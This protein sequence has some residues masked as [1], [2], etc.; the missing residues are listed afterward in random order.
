MNNSTLLNAFG[1]LNP[2]YLNRIQ[3]V[4]NAA[5]SE[6]PRTL[7]IRFDLHLPVQIDTD[8]L[9]ERDMGLRV[10][11]TDHRV[12]TRF[13]DALK[14]RIKADL[15][16]RA[17]D[18]KRVHSTS[19]RYVRVTEQGKADQQH[20]HIGILLNADSYY[21][22]HSSY[23]SDLGLAGMIR[24]AWASALGLNINKCR[25]LL[26]FPN[27]CF[28]NINRNAVGGVYTEQYYAALYRLGYLAKFDTKV[29]ILGWRNFS[30][31][32]G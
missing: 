6:Y 3:Y 4:L 22:G 28:Y 31:S 17:R 10:A 11:R 27:N 20:F 5:L 18:G 1:G 8:L 12:I 15:A 26:H 25:S 29:S 19:L 23:Q 7:V 13:I 16:R 30:C 32:H 9:S 24:E 14:A 21:F 2:Y